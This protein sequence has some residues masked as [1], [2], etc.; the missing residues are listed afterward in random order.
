M[1]KEQ[2][3]NKLHRLQQYQQQ[4][5]GIADFA[6]MTATDENGLLTIT[7]HIKVYSGEKRGLM[8]SISEADS[9]TVANE[10]MKQLSDFIAYRRLNSPDK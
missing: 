6:V 7:A 8:I 1:T 2:I 10:K 3:S 9:N 5:Q 4:L